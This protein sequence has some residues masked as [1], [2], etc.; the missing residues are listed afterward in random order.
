MIYQLPLKPPFHRR[1][2]VS[3]P[4]HPPSS[5]NSGGVGGGGGLPVPFFFFGGGG[6]GGG[7]WGADMHYRSERNER[8]GG[9]FQ[10]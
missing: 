8:E 1:A 9:H 4:E 3:K 2:E 7:G 10:R 6:G 5:E